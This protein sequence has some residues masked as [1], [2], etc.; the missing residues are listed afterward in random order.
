MVELNF[1]GL[2]WPSTP[3]PQVGQFPGLGPPTPPHGCGHSL[4]LCC[5]ALSDLPGEAST[6]LPFNFLFWPQAGSLLLTS[7]G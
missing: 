7:G 1:G 3:R 2:L 6:P 4:F 5:K